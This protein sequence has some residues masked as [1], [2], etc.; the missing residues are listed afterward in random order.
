MNIEGRKQSHCVATYVSSVENGQCAIYSISD[1]TLELGRK[2]V[3]NYTTSVL[4]INQFRGY[5]NCDA[6]KELYDMVK[7]ELT[8]F[9]GIDYENHFDSPY[10]LPF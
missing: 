7:S 8:K 3:D 2:W 9:N 6:P 5:K 4:F 1:Y 10:G